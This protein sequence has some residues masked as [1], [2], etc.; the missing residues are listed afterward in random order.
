AAAQARVHASAA[1][2]EARHAMA[3]ARVEMREGADEMDRGANEMREEARRL[4]DPAYRARQIEQNR[5]RGSTVTDAELID[6][7]RRLPEQADE[8]ERQAQRMR[9]QSAERI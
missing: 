6:L 1:R 9:E 4:R 3:R 7:S 8:L 5:A 2:E